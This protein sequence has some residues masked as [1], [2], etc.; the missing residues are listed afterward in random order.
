M[1]VRAKG[2]YGAAREVAP[3]ELATLRRTFR[4]EL[5][6]P[7]SEGYD[8][9]RG[10]WNLMVDH[11]PAL[12]A[13]CLGVV[14]VSSAIQF[15]RD[16][17]LELSVRGGGHS[18]VGHSVVDG[19]VM[20]DLSLMRGVLVDPGRHRAQ[21]QGGALIADLDR[22]TQHYG[23]A[24]TGGVA[25]DTGVAGYTLGGG[26][27]W[28]ARRFGLACDNLASVEL[29]TADGSRLVV[30]AESDP[31][32]FW[33][34]RGAGANYGV[35]TSFEFELHPLDHSVAHG[36]VFVDIDHARPAL[37]AFRDLL[38]DSDDAL[39]L[40]AFIGVAGPS[41]P[42]PESHR[43]RIVLGMS[44]IWVGEDP[45]GG[46]DLGQP[47]HV[48][49]PVLSERVMRTSYVELQ[50]GSERVRTRA[51]WKSSLL[52]A[53]EDDVLDAFIAA[54]IAANADGERATV[55]LIG[56]GG[57]IGRVDEEDSAYGH[58]D[59]VLDFLAISTWTD[60]A[61]D[62]ARMSAARAAWQEVSQV[63]DAG[64]Y[65]NNLGLEGVE[66]VRHAYG[67]EKFDRLARVKARIDPDNVFRHNQNIPPAVSG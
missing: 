59:A 8:A 55:E 62:E 47:L 48:A 1:A 49:A 40:D 29:V 31:E 15:A 7:G 45:S 6:L 37:R 65:V 4:G 20:I 16:H 18:I 17:A 54:G 30:S 28:L 46:D 42:V 36:D 14:D 43:G 58:R 5:M 66:R 13:R 38:A 53:F 67:A 41:L 25:Y 56:L 22:E 3:D 51:Y 44:W 26:Y 10:V 23:L 34:L 2:I 33:A 61:E 12:I 24:T 64:V 19:G 50:T 39:T 35:A 52:T 63:S 60:P 9:A 21:V 27:G 11:R 57:A 32:L